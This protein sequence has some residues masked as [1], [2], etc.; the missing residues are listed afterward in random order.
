[1]FYSILFPTQEQHMQP[2]QTDMPDCFKDLNLDQ[3]FDPILKSKNEFE[4]EGFFFTSLNDKE[5]IVYRQDVMRELE[6]SGLHRLF[7]VFS[8]TV[9][10]LGRYIE[11]IKI[12]LSSKSSYD[13]NYLARGRF[14]DYAD[15][16]CREVTALEAGLSSRRLFSAGLLNFSEYLS[17]YS[18]SEA[19]G[20]LCT[21]I[22]QLR[23]ELFTVKYCMLI[24]NGT[25]RVCKYEGQ[26][27]HSRQILVV[28]DKFRHGDVKNYRHKLTDEP[29][30]EHVEAAVLNMVAGL[31]KDMFTDLDRFCE[32][33][34]HFPDAAIVRFARE[35][36]FYLSWLDYI[37]SLQEACLPFNYPKICNTAEHLYDLDGFDLALAALMERK[38]VTNDI[39]LN[40]PE[41]I[42][43][44][45]GANQGGKS[46]FLRS[47]GQAQL[48]TDAGLIKKP[49][50]S[51]LKFILLQ[52]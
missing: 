11:T 38:T 7:T 3:I 29:Y 33:Y 5:I 34:L 21:Y 2:R 30:A 25:I 43:V 8:K 39:V 32:K 35:I 36:K 50:K 26:A 44:V 15:Y 37:R 14:L 13:N 52:K 28:F 41:R 42:I 47:L 31:Y 24:K 23:E 19:F 9:Y 48:M 45:T 22:K 16:Y 46:T 51:F 10:D 12:S 18:S 1:M 17:A 4:L 40:A 27:N 49:A 20:S 6:D